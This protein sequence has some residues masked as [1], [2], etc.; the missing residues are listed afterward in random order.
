[1]GDPVFARQLSLLALFLL[2]GGCAPGGLNAGVVDLRGASAPSGDLAQTCQLARRQETYDTA[3]GRETKL[4]LSND[5]ICAFSLFQITN[6]DGSPATRRP[7]DSAVLRVA[8]ASGVA[9]FVSTESATWVEYSPKPGFVGVDRF[10]F[11]LFPGG[12]VFPVD[13]E[14]VQ[15]VALRSPVQPDPKSAMI[16]FDH[17]QTDITAESRK[18]LDH[19]RAVLSDARFERWKIDL[20][21]HT[22]SSGTEAYN[23]RLSERRALEVRNYLVSRL[24][25]P[26]SRTSVAGYGTAVLLD[27]GRPLDGVNRRVHLT[28]R[29]GHH[30]ESRPRP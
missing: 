10:E 9:S 17:N 1:M 6:A 11:R 12:G 22:D 28:F 3:I 2:A 15:G 21:G 27:A 18:V 26:V 7:Y 29:R 25:V 4:R 8:P 24:S 14:V 30:T 20:A 23:N 13:V 5:G 19:L 16:Y